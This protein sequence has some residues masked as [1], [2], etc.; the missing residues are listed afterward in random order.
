MRQLARHDLMLPRRKRDT[1]PHRPAPKQRPRARPISR[2]ARPASAGLP[3]AAL[4]PGDTIAGPAIIE[5]PTTTIVVY[6][7]TSRG[8]A[9]GTFKVDRHAV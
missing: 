4:K 9:A 6:R 8:D 3:R 1:K 2:R 5:K 7:A